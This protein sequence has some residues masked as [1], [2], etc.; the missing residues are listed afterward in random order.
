MEKHIKAAYF[1][2]ILETISI[3][4]LDLR[5]SKHTWET[6]SENN[7]RYKPDS[8]INVNKTLPVQNFH[9]N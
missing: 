4:I 7:E 6:A 1:F 2:A 3:R 8:K 9:L 5:M